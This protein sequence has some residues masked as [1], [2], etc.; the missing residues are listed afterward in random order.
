LEPGVLA[1]ALKIAIEMDPLYRL[2]VIITGGT[3]L[4]KYRGETELDFYCSRLNAIREKLQVWIP[5]TFQVDPQDDEGW[6]RL[7]GTGILSKKKQE[8]MLAAGRKSTDE[9]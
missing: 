9:A 5:S 2:A 7:H 4:G 1:D 8:E 6:K 3:I